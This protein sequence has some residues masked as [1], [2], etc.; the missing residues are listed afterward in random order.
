[1]GSAWA[2]EVLWQGYAGA[3]E[4]E[5]RVVRRTART[6]IPE[7]GVRAGAVVLRVERATHVDGV[8]TWGPAP[9]SIEQLVINIAA[10]HG[11]LAVFGRDGT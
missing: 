9:S 5:L 4:S 1:M 11:R 8:K 6:S 10:M 2:N 7:E 3:Y